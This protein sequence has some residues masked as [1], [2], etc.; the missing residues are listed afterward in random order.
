[1]TLNLPLDLLCVTGFDQGMTQSPDDLVTEFCKLWASPDP[2]QLAS[3]FTEDAVY[4]NI[5]MDAVEG[6][7]AIKE[8]IAGF[9]AAFDGIDFQVHRQISDGNLVMNERTDVMRRKD[10]GEIPLPVMGTFEVVDGKIAA[11]RDYFDMATVTQ[12][13]T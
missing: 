13:F 7:E 9:T 3:Y 12:A 4:H 10:G 11:W 2:E 6:R 5:P 8:F 1:M